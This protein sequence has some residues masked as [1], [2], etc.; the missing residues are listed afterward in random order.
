[1]NAVKRSM[2]DPAAIRQDLELGDSLDIRSP[3][4]MRFLIRFNEHLDA[5]IPLKDYP[6][7]STVRGCLAYVADRGRSNPTA[8]K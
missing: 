2:V 4:F 7:L 8:E 3:Q 6:L 1:M 5:D